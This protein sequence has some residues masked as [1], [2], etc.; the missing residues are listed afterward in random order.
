MLISA[1]PF[2]FFAGT[3]RPT[4]IVAN[5]IIPLGDTTNAKQTKLDFH[6]REEQ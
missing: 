3:R 2:L 5:T 1:D 4:R 6:N